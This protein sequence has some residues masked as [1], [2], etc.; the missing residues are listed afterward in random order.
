MDD[1][2]EFYRRYLMS[3][4]RRKIS[5]QVCENSSA[6]NDTFQIP[7]LMLLLSCDKFFKFLYRAAYF[8][9]KE[10][11]VLCSFLLQSIFKAISLFHG[12]EFLKLKR[13]YLTGQYLCQIF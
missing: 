5:S 1:F 13:V 11:V 8:L 3:E 7:C 6:D 12:F 9:T 2:L 10:L 4:N